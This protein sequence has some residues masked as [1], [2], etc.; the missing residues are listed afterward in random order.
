MPYQRIRAAIAALASMKPAKLCCQTHSCL[1]AASVAEVSPLAT[2]VTT[3][4]LR[5]AA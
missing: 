4:A 5:F 3:A 1:R 2:L